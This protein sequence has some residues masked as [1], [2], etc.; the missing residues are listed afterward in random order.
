MLIIVFYF[1][2]KDLETIFS[3]F[4]KKKKLSG[5]SFGN[6]FSLEIRTFIIVF[7]EIWKPVLNRTPPSR[8]QINNLKIE[9]MRSRTLLPA[10]MT[11]RGG[12]VAKKIYHLRRVWVHLAILI[13][14]LVE[15]GMLAIIPFQT[16]IRKHKP[17]L[18]IFTI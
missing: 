11:E 10:Q 13:S 17:N 12:E 18:Y 5:K 6:N 14:F 9:A 4:L 1:W 2:E 16:R 8:P 15:L 7:S 3:F